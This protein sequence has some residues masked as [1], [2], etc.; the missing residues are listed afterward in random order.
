M[1]VM[2]GPTALRHIRSA[3]GPNRH[4]PVL[5][6]SADTDLERLVDKAGGFDGVVRKPIDPASLISMVAMAV[7]T[8][9]PCD[10]AIAG[11]ARAKSA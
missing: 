4:T 8:E 3:P 2:D 5:A 7:V 10:Q 1:P 11:S 9:P 6:F